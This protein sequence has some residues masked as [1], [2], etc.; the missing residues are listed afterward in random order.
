MRIALRPTGDWQIE[1]RAW[2]SGSLR[3]DG[4]DNVPVANPEALH[5]AIV[6]REGWPIAI[7]EFSDASTA[8][9]LAT[10]A[11]ADETAAIYARCPLEHAPASR[12]RFI[13]LLQTARPSWPE[14]ILLSELLALPATT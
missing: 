10:I 11:I 3:V 12:A 1:D 7:S 6:T 2:I 5:T 9:F 4:V 13:E 14:T 8:H